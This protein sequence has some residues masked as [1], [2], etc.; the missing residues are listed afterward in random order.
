MFMTIKLH[1]FT[2]KWVV[3][4]I[5]YHPLIVYS[6]IKSLQL[7]IFTSVTLFYFSK[8]NEESIAIER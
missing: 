2:N 7:N 6:D 1:P 3:A 4:F 5:A 8:T